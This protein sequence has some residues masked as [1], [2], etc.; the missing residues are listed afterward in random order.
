MTEEFT[1]P[2]VLERLGMKGIINAQSWVTF[3]GGSIMPPEVL[4]A[5]TESASGCLQHLG[6]IVKLERLL[7]RLPEPTLA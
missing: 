5:M 7:P 3:L 6:C 2:P 4:Q 1:T